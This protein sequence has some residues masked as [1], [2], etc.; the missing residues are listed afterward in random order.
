[1]Q[2]LGTLQGKGAGSGVEGSPWSGIRQLA[3]IKYVNYSNNQ[4]K[5]LA[6]SA[7]GF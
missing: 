3:G 2:A 4:D 7:Q 1:V 6:V 5:G